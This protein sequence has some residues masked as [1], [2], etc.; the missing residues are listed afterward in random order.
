MK[1][2]MIGGIAILAIAL[3][4]AFNVSVS[5]Q[6]QDAASMLALANVEALA[7]EADTTPKG[8]PSTKTITK[9]FYDSDGNLIKTETHSEPCCA[10]GSLPCSA[11]PC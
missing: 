8:Y 1:T 5:N 11:G 4:V 7:Q 9:Y 10:S 6:K 3:A 2:K